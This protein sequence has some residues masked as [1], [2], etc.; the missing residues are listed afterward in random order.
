MSS[1]IP[2]S[3]VTPQE[4]AG[5]SAVASGNGPPTGTAAEH[6]VQEA[7]EVNGVAP[8]VVDDGWL[9]IVF[10]GGLSKAER[11]AAMH[12]QSRESLEELMNKERVQTNWFSTGGKVL[13]AGDEQSMRMR[14]CAWRPLCA[15]HD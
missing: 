15:G 10:G 8:E 4:E 1:S 12:G 5:H 11:F 3:P 7:D 2:S 13:N 14:R 9:W 6:G